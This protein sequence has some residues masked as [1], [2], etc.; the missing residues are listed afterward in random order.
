ME[1]GR[2]HTCRDPTKRKDPEAVFLMPQPV[3][4]AYRKQYVGQFLSQHLHVDV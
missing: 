2:K 4:G 1:K 3:E